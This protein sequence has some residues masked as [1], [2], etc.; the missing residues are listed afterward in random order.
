[1]P[2][3]RQAV[4]DQLPRIA[5]P[6]CGGLSSYVV[7][8]VALIVPLSQHPLL[9]TI[10]KRDELRVE[11]CFSLTGKREEETPRTAAENGPPIVYTLSRRKPVEH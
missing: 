4:L 11:T 3:H 2:Y 1:M 8:V 7:K 5:L 10:E 6:A 9:G